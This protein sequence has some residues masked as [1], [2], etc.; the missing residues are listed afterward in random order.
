M[1][2]NVSTNNISS[3]AR[4]V[5]FGEVLFDVF[6]D[7]TLLGGAAYNVAAHLH[8]FGLNPLFISRIGNDTLG[9]KIQA[10]MEQRGIDMTGVQKDDTYPTGQVTIAGVDDNYTFDILANQAYDFID[11]EEAL[12]AVGA[13]DVALLYHGSLAV[14][15]MVSGNSLTALQKALDAPVF[16]DINLRPPWWTKTTCL[17]LAQE[18][19]WL[20]LNHVE[21]DKLAQDAGDMHARAESLRK[22]LGLETLILTCAEKG[23][24]I[25]QEGQSTPVTCAP[26]L[27]SDLVDTVGA[28]DAFSAVTLYGL[29]NGWTTELIL[30]RALEFAAE[31]CRNR[32]ATYEDNSVYMRFLEKWNADAVAA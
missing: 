27:V 28:G 31:M 14:R 29:M 15:Q 32:G 26:V 16:V 3:G 22:D 24:F 13:Q 11:I 30:A 23:A 1:S 6:P 4:P 2:N 10:A 7:K 17:A 8:G 21:L 12:K 9:E 25:F 20:K 5:I 19:R 18:A